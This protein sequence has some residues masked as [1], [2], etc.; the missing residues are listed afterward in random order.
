MGFVNGVIDFFKELKY[1]LI[2]D[3]IVIDMVNGILGWFQTLFTDGVKW[4]SDMV[5]SIIGF[6]G[7]LLTGALEKAGSLVTDVGGKIKS[8]KDEAVKKFDE[9]KKGAVDNFKTAVSDVTKKAGEMKKNAAEKLKEIP[10]AASEKLG[11]FKSTV[12]DKFKD[13]KEAIKTKMGESVDVVKDKLARLK[14]KFSNVDLTNVATNIIRGFISGLKQAWQGVVQ[15]AN[16]AVSNLKNKF[17][18][19]LQIQ[20]P[21]KV[22]M[23]Y[24][25]F[26]VEGFNEGLEKMDDSTSKVVDD[27]VDSF[28]NVQVNMTPQLTPMQMPQ[29]DNSYK[30]TGLTDSMNNMVGQL[31]STNTQNNETKIILQVDGRT[32]YETVVKQN[33]QQLLR[34]GKSLLAY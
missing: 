21:S 34:T 25:K 3:P 14:E 26:T 16:E 23:E 29:T 13:A 20:S 24:G 18:E 9:F 28:S 15:W 33:N 31:A 22:F 19:A 32:L 8:F 27:W 6:F 30:G 17:K 7:D 4:I 2:G 11:K 5:K 10:S 1:N 12:S